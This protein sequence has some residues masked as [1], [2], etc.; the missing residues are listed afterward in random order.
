MQAVAGYSPGGL[1]AQQLYGGATHTMP[2]EQLPPPGSYAAAYVQ[3]TQLKTGNATASL[4]LGILGCFS[5]GLLGIGSVIGLLLGIRATIKAKREPELFGAKGTAIGGIVTNSLA[6]LSIIP[7]AL[8][9]AIAIP[10]IMAAQMAANEFAAISY[11]NDLGTAQRA[12]QGLNADGEFGTL[13]QLVEAGLLA[14][15]DN[16]FFGYEVELR[17]L[18]CD[19]SFSGDTS[20]CSRFEVVA[21]PRKYDSSGRRSFYLTDDY[22]IRAGDKRGKEASRDDEPLKDYDSMNGIEQD[23][24]SD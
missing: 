20:H 15:V 6:L 5:L 4:V 17:L 7:V 2:V 9:A 12:Y 1:A 14:S 11:L 8:F 13:D 3:P 18:E 21:T 24:L 19:E 22:V 23:W 16:K 10:N